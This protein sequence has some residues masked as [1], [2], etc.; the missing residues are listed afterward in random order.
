MTMR[1]SHA[2]AADAGQRAASESSDRLHAAA[3]AATE[4]MRSAGE[5][6]AN[7]VNEGLHDTKDRLMN[8]A[9]KAGSAAY[10]SVATT[11]E[12]SV[13]TLEQAIGRNPVGALVAAL[14]IGLVLGLM[15]RR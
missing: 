1:G 11:A 7:A 4:G 9:S 8:E 12:K 13:A 15:A 3:S 6:V 14:G 10:K 2:N 5:N